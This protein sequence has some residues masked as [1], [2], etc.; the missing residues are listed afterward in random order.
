M[1]EQTYLNTV[2]KSRCPPKRKM[3]PKDG[4]YLECSCDTSLG[5]LTVRCDRHNTG[6]C[7]DVC[8]HDD[9]RNDRRNCK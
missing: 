8:H 1:N 2:C 4:C 6:I 5:R 9:C 7:L 3:K